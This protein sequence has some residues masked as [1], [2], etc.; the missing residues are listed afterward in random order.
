[1]LILQL[2]G[3]LEAM[4][5]TSMTEPSFWS[6]NFRNLAIVTLKHPDVQ[7]SR[8]WITALKIFPLFTQTHCNFLISPVP[9]TPLLLL[10]LMPC[11]TSHLK[12]K[13]KNAEEVVYDWEHRVSGN[14][15]HWQ[16]REL[17][18]ECLGIIQST[19]ET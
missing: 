11:F 14:G 6:M 8:V 16:L 15:C 5:Y 13:F 4:V 17:P 2:N 9:F 1:M 19:W 18:S 10:F 12:V 7:R 3:N